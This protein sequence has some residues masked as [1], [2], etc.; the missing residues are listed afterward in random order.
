MTTAISPGFRL[1]PYEI[2]AP[3]GM[4]GM[5]EVWRARD[6]RLDRFVAIKVLPAEVA[7]D[8][9]RRERMEREA[10]AV[11]ALNHPHICALYDIGR[12]DGTDFLVMELLEGET[13]ADRLVR[14]RLPLSDLIRYGRE[15]SQA[16]DRAHR[17]GIVHRDLKPGNIMITPSGAKL[18]DF[19]LAKAESSG[20]GAAASS[21]TEKKP[22]TAEG[23]IVGTMQYMSPEQIETGRADHRSD[24]FA[25][26]A[27]LYQMATGRPAFEGKTT[28]SLIAAILDHDPAPITAV[29]PL[30][31]PELERL[32]KACL[33]K[34]ADDRI[35]SARDVA[36]ILTWLE[37]AP[38]SAA[39]PPRRAWPLLVLAGAIAAAA[40][41][42]LLTRRAEPAREP[43]R[44]ILTPPGAEF[45]LGRSPAVPSPDGQ[46][47]VFVAMSNGKNVLW[48]Q[49]VREGVSRPLSGTDN[50]YHPFSS[51]DS[52][53]IGFFDDT[54]LMRVDAD[55]GP[56]QVVTSVVGGRG[57]T[58]NQRGIILFAL[59]RDGLYQVP[60]TGGQPKKVTTIAEN[61]ADHRWPWFLPD[62]QHFLYLA[63]DENPMR[64][65]IFLGKLGTTLRKHIGESSSRPVVARGYLVT[66][67]G[68][69]LFAQRFDLD[70]FVLAGEPRPLAAHL[71]YIGGTANAVFAASDGL[72]TYAR[73]AIDLQLAWVDRSGRVLERIAEPGDYDHVEISPDGRRVA[74]TI[75]VAGQS[76]VWLYERGRT[77]GIR[78]AATQAEE[79]SPAWSPDG[80][81]IAYSSRRGG[82][83][84]VV[85]VRASRG[86]DRERV[87]WSVPAARVFPVGWSGDSILAV[88]H[89][90]TRK[91][92]FDIW[93]Y[94]IRSGTA[95][96][97]VTGPR[98]DLAPSLSPDGK[99]LAWQSNESG[100]WHIYVRPTEGGSS[101]RVSDEGGETP[102][103]S[104]DGRELFY[105]S[106]RS[107]MS[108][109][110]TPAGDFG[111]P[112]KLFDAGIRQGSTGPGHYHPF[113]VSPDGQRF[114]FIEAGES[115]SRP[116]T[117]VTDWVGLVEKRG[118]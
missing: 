20:L 92:I 111:D 103:W 64:S 112:K 18:L 86:G 46:R 65:N 28:A 6:T 45:D 29:A 68:R 43:V 5:G 19:G 27:V 70:K 95:R 61:E 105:I 117:I 118:S 85:L 51:P 15:I 41:A 116:M 75:N 58:W 17:A 7:G 104:A 35:Q 79:E 71:H 67:R 8:P 55:G 82:D 52:N 81:Q 49:R 10:R 63:R 30:T 53:S 24:I 3:L 84:A 88:V 38:R 97:L 98:S 72:L 32:V 54:R 83:N 4:G 107:L 96:P 9:H 26:G 22:L 34:N 90:P 13:L 47:I 25:L 74:T 106:N 57:G 73:G 80:S 115:S 101:V 77:A 99:W 76:D 89:S 50:A 109:P 114:L 2:T 16:L 59:I 66:T 87:L 56:V 33:A 108:I 93:L 23:T 113:D 100:A 110:V 48:V 40:A 60:A 36:Q 12:H 78:F 69:N 37:S 102:R 21:L 44:A 14:G 39:Q 1:G 31:P 91:I 42:I 94:S 62:G 11:S